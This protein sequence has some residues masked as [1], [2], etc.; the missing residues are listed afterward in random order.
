MVEY[1]GTYQ[2]ALLLKRGSGYFQQSDDGAH[3][4]RFREFRISKKVAE[5]IMA[6]GRTDYDMVFGYNDTNIPKP[7]C[8]PFWDTNPVEYLTW[9]RDNDPSPYSE[10]AAEALA[11]LDAV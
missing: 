1:L 2:G 5:E 10:R 11:K 9:H 4:P 8:T 6:M 3:M 7:A